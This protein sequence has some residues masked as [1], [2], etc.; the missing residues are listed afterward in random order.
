M[1][2][3]KSGSKSGSKGGSLGGSKGGKGASK[4]SGKHA[5]GRQAASGPTDSLTRKARAEIAERLKK[6]DAAEQDGE[7]VGQREDPQATLHGDT[8]AP[9]DAPVDGLENAP[10]ASPAT[11]GMTDAADAAGESQLVGPAENEH[12]P[13]ATSPDAQAEPL[14]AVGTS[15][16]GTEG[17]VP[18]SVTPP[19]GGE[20]P[21]RVRK[22]AAEPKPKRVSQ[23]DAAAQV[24]AEAGI[25]MGAKAMVAE[26]EAKGLW[27]SPGGKTPD[28]TLNAAIIREIATKGEA[29]RFSKHDRGLYIAKAR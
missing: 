1:S 11:L 13:A 22:P 12:Q 8:P 19:Q 27:K 9:V 15:A 18:A 6:L 24:L 20:K 16:P 25:P 4:P 26:M 29:S 21:K 28:A 5:A 10:D 23:L 7:L 2:K 3:S 17:E 14:A